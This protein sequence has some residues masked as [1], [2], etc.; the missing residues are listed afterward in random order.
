MTEHTL[1]GYACYM[2]YHIRIK[3]TSPMLGDQHTRDN[4]RRFDRPASLN[5]YIRLDMPRWNWAISEALKTSD[6]FKDIDPERV[7]M[8]HKLRTPKLDL[9]NRTWLKENKRTGQKTRCREMFESINEG[10]EI[11][12]NVLVSEDPSPDSKDIRR[13]PTVEE[14]EKM[15]SVMGDL[16]GISP[17]GSQFGYGRFSLISVKPAE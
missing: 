10:A 11:T 17:W 3:L 7:M 5:G 8:E 2:L 1:F 13:A 14:L 4:T 15:F 6:L 9:H 12:L 16:V